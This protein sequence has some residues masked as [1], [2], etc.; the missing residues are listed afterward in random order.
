MINFDPSPIHTRETE[1]HLI[2]ILRSPVS[3]LCPNV[4]IV[5]TFHREGLLAA[6][7]LAGME[8][9]RTYAKKFGLHIQVIAMLDRPDEDTR[10]VIVNHPIFNELDWVLLIDAGDQGISR[11]IGVFF[12]QG[13]AIGV[14]D[15]DDF[16]S[17]NWISM[18][19]ELVQEYGSSVVIHPEYAVS[20]ETQHVLQRLVDQRKDIYPLAACVTTHPWVSTTI[21]HAVIFKKTPYLEAR[22]EETGFGY[23][24]WHW[25]IE[26]LSKGVLHITANETALYYRR[27][28][29]STLSKHAHHRS[30]VRPSLFFSKPENW[31]EGFPLI[32]EFR[33]HAKIFPVLADV[34]LKC[35]GGV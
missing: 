17:K 25:N 11:N 23:E 20:F 13:E 24:D 14:M 2:E 7:S 31:K 8:R 32:S 30:I 9:I 21:A 33:E 26:V 4:S 1:T 15:G 3:E 16:C 29:N 28:S 18:A 10:N 19:W 5:M 6:W 27:R 35:K 22:V 34:N 12:A